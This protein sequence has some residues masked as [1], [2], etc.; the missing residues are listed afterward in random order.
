MTEQPGIGYYLQRTV[1]WLNQSWLAE[2]L[3]AFLR[4]QVGSH[5][6][7]NSL[8]SNYETWVN[9]RCRFAMAG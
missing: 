5:E 1:Y 7:G 8:P 6:V 2:L 9:W 4:M 3:S